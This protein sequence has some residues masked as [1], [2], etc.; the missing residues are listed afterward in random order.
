MMA[1]YPKNEIRIIAHIA[2]IG[3]NM[4]LVRARHLVLMNPYS[5]DNDHGL[6]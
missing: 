3:T 4:E 1:D 5:L 6:S 2:A